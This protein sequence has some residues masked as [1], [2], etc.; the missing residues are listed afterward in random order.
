[1]SFA[2]PRTW[3]KPRG[4]KWFRG[5]VND[6]YD[7][8]T[9]IQP[10]PGMGIDGSETDFGIILS[11]NLQPGGGVGEEDNNHYEFEVIDFS[12]DTGAAVL[13]YDGFVYGPND[14]GNYPDGM[15]GLDDYVIYFGGMTGELEIWLEIWVNFETWDVTSINL[16]YGFETPSDN[17]STIFVTVAFVGVD[18]N[19]GGTATVVRDISNAI[20][21]DYVI[22]RVQDITNYAFQIIDASGDSG[23]EVQILDGD[24]IDQ[25]GVGHTPTGMGADDFVMAVD[26]GD[27]I[28]LEITH[29]AEWNVLDP[30]GIGHGSSVPDDTG[31]VSYV[32]IGYVGVFDP[33]GGDPT[34]VNEIHNTVCGDYAFE[35]EQDFNNYAFEMLDASDADGAKVL[36]LDGDVIDQDGNGHTPSGMGADNYVVGVID[37]DEI[38][39]AIPHDD[40]WNIIDPVTLGVGA[41]P[42]DISGVSYVTIGY[43]SVFDP[44]DSPTEVDGIH[45]VVLGD[46]H[47]LPPPEN[48]HF[49]FQIIDVSSGSGL[50]VLIYDGVVYGPNDDGIDPS[51]MPSGNSYVLGVADG[52]EIWVGVTFDVETDDGVSGEQ[53]TS[54][55]IDHGAVTP[56]DVF[57]TMYFTIGHID[58]NYDGPFPV[59][60][61]V[62]EICG[63]INIWIPPDDG[64]PDGSSSGNDLALV[65]DKDTGNRVWK[66]VCAS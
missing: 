18:W 14:D 59:T 49:D 19:A 27:S 25:D 61:P 38:Y 31:T 23:A 12:D 17:D 24:V 33:G 9:Q 15:T 22:D 29:D 63:D 43:V 50:F 37:G 11:S 30:V 34:F 26:D 40:D 52:D 62:N 5:V 3:A 2:E 48:N 42:G 32:E 45:N 13:V 46:Y 57:P 36:I 54:V 28:W 16:N 55:W 65:V 6:I 60:M 39:L 56:D 21:G 47:F 53:V 64:G 44:G 1:M 8:M 4:P 51:G 7:Q 20:C 41:T 35:P 58:V 10:I 66:K